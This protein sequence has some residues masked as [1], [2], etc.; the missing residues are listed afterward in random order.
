MVEEGKDVQDDQTGVEI[1]GTGTSLSR[2]RWALRLSH[3]VLFG[4]SPTVRHK[5]MQLH[6]AEG[7]LA[8][9]GMVEC[10]GCV[11]GTCDLRSRRGHR[12]IK[13]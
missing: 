4:K 6:L 13:Q 11:S 7:Y 3:V 8:R 2:T 5:E 10:L 9:L 1:C 12:H